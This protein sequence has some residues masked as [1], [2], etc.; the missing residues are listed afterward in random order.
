MQRVIFFFLCLSFFPAKADFNFN[1]SC[2]KA[3]DHIFN[4]EFE[5]AKNIIEAEKRSNNKNSI[6]Y[7]LDNYIDFLSS[8]ISEEKEI[9]N[10]FKEEQG[11]RMERIKSD[12]PS[13]PFYLYL[14]AEMYLQ[15]GFTRFKFKEYFTAAYEI[16]KAYRLLTENSKLFPD[17]KANQKSLGFLHTIIGSIPAEYKWMGKI[18]GM[19]GTIQ[20]GFEEINL[21]HNSLKGTSYE[22]I[23]PET[24]F[25]LTFM[26]L[27]ILKKEEV[28]E[29]IMD[30]FVSNSNSVSPLIKFVQANIAIHQGKNDK[31][32]AILSDYKLDKNQ[33]PL[34]YIY[35]QL[36]MCKLNKLDKSAEIFF[37][38]YINA[39]K[40]TSFV[41][42]AYQKLAWHGLIFY[43]P[44]KYKFYMSHSKSEGADLIDEDKQAFAEAKNKGFPNIT[45][46]KSRLL[47]DGGYYMEA[48]SQLGV[49]SENYP[50]I[51]DKLELI[52]R[53]A[54]IY[55]KSGNNE[56]AIQYYDQ[57]INNGANQ[58]FYFA[59]NAA[60]ELGNLYESQ[61]NKAKA[62]FYFKKCLSIRNHEYQN[63]IDQK[64]K[65]GLNRLGIYD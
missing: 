21:A 54:R 3:Y 12:N 7:F 64:A 63:S 45:L 41:K 61:K 32:I 51:K 57:T 5:A 40:G 26:N 52:Y 48:L 23:Y 58:S 11:Q 53:M 19:T 36:G 4:L 65:A 14:Q 31:A 59:A 47:F 30:D 24:S 2:R 35:Y 38:A 46:L 8:F 49:K 20:Q 37:L 18:V 16:N 6:P 29:K 56:K 55:H 25:L 50:S 39:F 27:S 62:E 13:S 44:D 10:K 9:F 43:G 33:F 28:A 34:A 42:A 17:F 15:S 60:L 22:Y 1:N